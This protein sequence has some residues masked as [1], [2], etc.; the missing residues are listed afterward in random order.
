MGVV[1]PCR[2]GNTPRSVLR[3]RHVPQ[4]ALERLDALTA[5]IGKSILRGVAWSAAGVMSDQAPLA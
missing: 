5:G 1:H 2:A 3:R 4:Q